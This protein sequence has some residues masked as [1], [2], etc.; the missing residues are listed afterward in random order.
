MSED[1][2]KEQKCPPTIEPCKKYACAIQKCL[3]SN[4]YN[5]DK[6]EYAIEAMRKCCANLTTYS[7]ICEGMVKSDRKQ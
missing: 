2:K 1:G 7:Y 4:N 5:Q 6:C 3:E